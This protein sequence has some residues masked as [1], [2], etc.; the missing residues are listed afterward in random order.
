MVTEE[1]RTEIL[2]NCENTVAMRNIDKFKGHTG[3]A[4][5]GTF[6]RGIA[7][8]QKNEKRTSHNPSRLRGR[9]AK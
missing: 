3:S 5:H 7:T 4:I 1:K 6:E 2:I 8:M 9:G